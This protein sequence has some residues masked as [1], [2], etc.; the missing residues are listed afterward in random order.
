MKT[1]FDLAIKGWGFPSVLAGLGVIVLFIDNRFR[2]GMISIS[3]IFYFI[4]LF[5]R[6]KKK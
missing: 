6:S 1:K 2:K 5:L 4:N 3:I